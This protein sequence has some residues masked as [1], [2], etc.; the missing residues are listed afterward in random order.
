MKVFLNFSW[1]A[2]DDWYKML[3]YCMP[4]G[5]DRAMILP[6][7]DPAHG[8]SLVKKF[9][10]KEGEY[11]GIATVR[12]GASI[13]CRDDLLSALPTPDAR[14]IEPPRGRSPTPLLERRG[15]SPTP[16]IERRGRSPT[17]LLLRR[18]GGR[19]AFTIHV[20]QD[21]QNQ[22]FHPRV[23]RL[24]WTLMFSGLTRYCSGVNELHR[25]CSFIK[26]HKSCNHA[27]NF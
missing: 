3:G 26:G 15:R 21:R 17:L 8:T 11:T 18:K 23:Y 6:A 24:L 13:P 14:L 4:R 16:L 19:S 5:A 2:L 7:I 25:L 22:A 12:V 9:M 1:G 10:N 20:F 27:L